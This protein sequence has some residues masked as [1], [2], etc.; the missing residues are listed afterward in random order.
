MKK[1]AK[2]KVKK[3]QWLI[4][5]AITVCISMWIYGMVRVY[6]PDP[7]YIGL[8]Q[9]ID[10]GVGIVILTLVLSG[11]IVTMLFKKNKK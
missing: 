10:V 7:I 4:T 6:F 2:R 8:E 9:Y 11:L 5:L 3:Y 1:N